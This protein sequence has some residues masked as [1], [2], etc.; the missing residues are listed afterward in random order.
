MTV[1]KC[2]CKHEYQDETYGR[3]NRVH[4]T[5]KHGQHH[6]TVCGGDPIKRRMESA[7]KN[8]LKGHVGD[9]SYR[10]KYVG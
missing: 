6:C 8:F 7:A 3:G 2:N 10:T 9:A 1:K 4:T 5:D